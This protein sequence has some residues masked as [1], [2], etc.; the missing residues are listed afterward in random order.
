MGHEDTGTWAEGP[1]TGSWEPSQEYSPPGSQRQRVRRGKAC[2]KRPEVKYHM[3]LSGKGVIGSLSGSGVGDSSWISQEG[4]E[5][6][7]G[8]EAMPAQGVLGT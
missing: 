7:R 5:G 6:K 1:G 4:A 2:P 8:N 3:G